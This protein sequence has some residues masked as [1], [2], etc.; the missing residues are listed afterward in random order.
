MENKPKRDDL[1]Y[2]TDNK[3]KDRTYDF[4]KLKTIKSFERKICNN[5]LSLDDVIELQIR[6]K[7]VIDIIKESTK[8]KES[9]KK[10]K[11]STNS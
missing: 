2:K 7:D 5:D 10:E 11:R 9:V 3:K 8:P 6:W 4:Q 1:I